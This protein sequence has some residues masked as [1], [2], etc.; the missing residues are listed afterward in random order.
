MPIYQ[1][2]C[3]HCQHSFE[4]LVRSDTVVACPQCGA[5]DV[6]KCVTAPQAPGKS[7]AIIQRARVQAAKEG[8]FSNFSKA[9]RPK[10]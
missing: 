5:T 2:A 4:K 3:P 9:E 7:K 1:Y 10:V 6:D 8:H